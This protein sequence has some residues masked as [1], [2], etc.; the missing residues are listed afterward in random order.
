[1]KVRYLTGKMWMLL[2][3][4]A[5]S[6]GLFAG[7]QSGTMA[8]AATNDEQSLPF[9]ATNM[10]K[11]IGVTEDNHTMGS[12]LSEAALKASISEAGST[13]SLHY[14]RM[15]A[16]LPSEDVVAW[17]KVAKA[18]AAE[19]RAKTGRV[20][21]IIQVAATP[22]TITIGAAGIPRVDAVDVASYQKWMTQADYNKL[23]SLGVKT[24]VVKISEG[25]S[26]QNPY[27]KTSIQMAKKANLRV[28]VYDYALFNSAAGAAS[29]AR[30]AAKTLAQL[31]LSKDTLIFAD[32]EEASCVAKYLTNYWQTLAGLGYTNHGVY[33]GGG[34]SQAS[35][36]VAT[37]GKARTWWAQYPITPT[38]NNLLNK[39]YGAWQ[40]SS[41]A[42]IPTSPNNRV[43]VSHDYNGLLLGKQVAPAQGPW[44]AAE[45][46]VTITHTGYPVYASFNFNVKA[47]ISN[48][49]HHTYHVTGLYHHAN[50][51]TYLSLYDSANKW[52]GYINA[53]GV[54]VGSGQQGAHVADN[55]YATITS[56]GYPLYNNF[57]W[58]VRQTGG[59]VYHQTF[60]STGVYHHSSGNTYLSLYDNQGNWQ[61][62]INVNGV[63]VGSGPQGGHLSDDRYVSVTHTGYPI[64]SGFDWKVKTTGKA[65]YQHTYHSTGIY[66]HINGNTYLSLYDSQNRWIGYINA[67]GVDAAD[68]QSSVKFNDKRYVTVTHTG[69]PIYSN[70]DWQQKMSGAAAYKHTY[71]SKG[72][73]AHFS[74][75][76]YLSL[77]DANDQWVGY[78]NAN[79][80]S[81]APGQQG[82]YFSDNRYVTVTKTGY[83]IYSGFDWN[84]KY[85]GKAAYQHTYRSTGM[86]YHFNGNTYLSL[87]DLNSKWVGYVNANAVSVAKG[88][89]GVMFADNRQVKVTH[90]GY[91]VYRDFSWH[92]SQ[93]GTAVYGKIFTSKGVYYN[94][95]GSTY[96]SLYDAAGKWWG[97][98]NANGVD[99]IH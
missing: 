25:D 64:Y 20:Q 62:Y 79:G 55:R 81:V 94:I 97:Y 31:G 68:S 83:A 48:F 19:D 43:D 39:D 51:S 6:A 46:Y 91:P 80:V 60:H 53:N 16:G 47:P 32:M 54:D 34:Y 15:P 9:M 99:M 96:L 67:N 7:G 84:V 98:I 10:H 65:A 78:I 1:M 71:Y 82:S 17:T 23:A 22:K 85:A 41:T 56:T 69:Y 86:Y 27:A 38:A 44:I 93:T 2:L 72:Q 50:G 90:T 75:N 52:I 77:Y 74:G 8:H 73:Y 66:S 49:Y 24:I 3:A 28:A 35:T 5:A 30:Y 13:A 12:A 95:N 33:T 18:V 40:F 87:Y 59:A 70:F 21:Q 63:T 88:T 29:E 11:N 14:L 42:V 37:V 61:G 45:E 92:V 36:A 57:N 4:M 76:T 58:Q 26:Y 89:Q